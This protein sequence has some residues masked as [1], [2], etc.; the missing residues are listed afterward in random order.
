MKKTVSIMFM[1][2]VSLSFSQIKQTKINNPVVVGKINGLECNKQDNQYTFYYSDINYTHIENTKSFYF[3]DENN[4]FNALFDIIM[5]GFNIVPKED[6][7]IQI[8]NGYL[9]L[10][11]K[12]VIGVVN[13]TMHIKQGIESGKTVYLTKR[14]IIKLFGKNKK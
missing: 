1:L 9:I 10:K 4:D 5:N 13:L 12:K 6:V 14:K 2:V 11:Y 3:L 7:E 8:P